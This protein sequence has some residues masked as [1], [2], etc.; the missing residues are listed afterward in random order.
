VKTAGEKELNRKTTKGVLH[1]KKERSAK[2]K[3]GREPSP[4][5]LKNEFATGK[6]ERKEGI[7]IRNSRRKNG[8]SP[9]TRQTRHGRNTS[10]HKTLKKT[11]FHPIQNKSAQGSQRGKGD[12]GRVGKERAEANQ[13]LCCLCGKTLFGL[14]EKEDL[15]FLSSGSLFEEGG[16]KERKGMGK[17][18]GFPS[19]Y[20]GGG[21]GYAVISKSATQSP[22]GRGERVKLGRGS[23]SPKIRVRGLGKEE[24]NGV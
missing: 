5:T 16:S 19:Q 21:G 1:Q 9:K 4:L 18:G 22:E 3:K 10:H 17:D 14:G 11:A 6:K 12:S 20:G 24:K 2:G 7:T 13:P 15:L 8:G 23:T